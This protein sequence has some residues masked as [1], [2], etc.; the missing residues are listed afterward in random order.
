[1]KEQKKLVGYYFIQ[2]CNVQLKTF[3]IKK[4]K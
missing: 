1:M 2:V 4:F 3:D